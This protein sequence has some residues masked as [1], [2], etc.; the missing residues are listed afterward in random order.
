[1][2]TKRIKSLFKR[3]LTDIFRDKKTL[4]M[5]VLVPLLL[6]PLLIVA[7]TL[8][9]SAVMTDQEEKIYKAAFYEVEEKEKI[10]DVFEEHEKELSY[11]LEILETENPEK[12]LMDKELDAYVTAEEKEGRLCYS[13]HYLSAETDSVTA[14]DVLYDGL[15][16]FREELRKEAVDDL[17]LDEN[18]VLYPISYE[19]ADMSSKEESMGSML[20]SIIP[21]LMITSICLG[22]MYPTIDVTAGE[23][24]RGTLE[25]LLTLP[26]TNFELIMSK[27][28]AVSVI[29][30]T[31]AFLN[32]LSM[33]A[34]FGFM[35]SFF[36]ESVQNLSF[37]FATF[38]PAILFS[39]IIMLVFALLVTAVCMCVC[40]FAKS[41]KEA[42]NY[43]TPV[44]LV[45]MFSSYA[46]MLP[47][48]KLTAATAAVPI[49]NVTLLIKDLFSFQYNYGLFAV[50]LFCNVAYSLLTV[51][52]LGRIYN[53]ESVLFAEGFT[54]LKIFH[55]RSEMKQGQLPGYGD[56]LL[57]LCILIL[58]IFYIG[59]FATIKLGFLG[60]LVQ[61]LLILLLPVCYGWYVKT[62][63]KKLFSLKAPGLKGV[64]ASLCFLA[65]GF[66]LNLVLSSV[67]SMFL[68]DSSESLQ[69]QF[70]FLLQAPFWAIVVVMAVLPAI[71]EELMFRG[72]VFGTMKGKTSPVMAVLMTGFIFGCYHFSLVKLIPTAFLG[73]LLAVLVYRTGSI[74]PAML[75]HFANNFISL[76]VSKYQEQ[77]SET[78]PALMNLDFGGGQ[79]MV[80]AGMILAGGIFLWL[81]WRISRKKESSLINEGMI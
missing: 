58:G 47:D 64:L 73:C 77:L 41:F 48:F 56:L 74:F 6:Y 30:C 68:K 45:F 65:G 44:L 18:V 5:M 11:Q 81:G 1:M 53:S 67:L 28:L 29:A 80:F 62:D 57:L 10:Q 55:K 52:V 12:S 46:G 61:Q 9:T 76:F 63:F 40:I 75:M 59:S 14:A 8:I 38:V 71:G 22:A 32:I 24:E 69:A 37:D 15:E 39:V 50:V 13:I 20:G 66:C 72:F 79:V 23:R 33:M 42:N 25:T 36:A 34:A 7:M 49:V 78:Y 27:F 60:V 54:S 19:K 4:V 3:E 51:M 26:V 21:F 35:F 16:L 17:G 43:I 2:S 70:D 31:S